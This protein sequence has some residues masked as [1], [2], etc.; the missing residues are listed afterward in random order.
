M[1][2]MVDWG[3]MALAFAAM[4]GFLGWLVY[5]GLSMTGNVPNTPR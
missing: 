5:F 3:N 1:A 4:A 2:P